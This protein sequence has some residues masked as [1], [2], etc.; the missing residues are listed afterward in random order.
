MDEEDGD[1]RLERAVAC[2]PCCGI[3]GSA[4]VQTT[5]IALSRKSAVRE[6]AVRRAE[7]V[8][9]AEEEVREDDEER[10]H[11]PA[12]RALGQVSGWFGIRLS[13]SSRPSDP[14]AIAAHMVGRS[15]R[16]RQNRNVTTPSADVRDE[17]DVVKNL[18]RVVQG[19][20]RAR[21]PPD[22]TRARRSA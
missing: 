12:D 15:R 14:K 19:R 21:V 16:R 8:R 22:C 17:D 6:P 20:S 4:N 11:D 7:G 1:E 3:V 13:S 9:E 18:D 10:D 5:R 2:L